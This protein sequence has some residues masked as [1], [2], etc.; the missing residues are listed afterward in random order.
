MKSGMSLPQ[1]FSQSMRLS[2]LNGLS[3]VPKCACPFSTML[4][5]VGTGRRFE[6]M[7]SGYSLIIFPP[8]GI[9]IS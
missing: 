4:S 2:F 7:Y 6:E 8:D 5:G 1:G 3:N 9:K